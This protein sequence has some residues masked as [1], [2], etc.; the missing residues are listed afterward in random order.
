MNE[1]EQ[2]IRDIC[3]DDI[4]LTTLSL[5]FIKDF[6]AKCSISDFEKL[7]DMEYDLSQ[8]K[9]YSFC[10]CYR[11]KGCDIDEKGFL[12]CIECEKIISLT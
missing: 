7:K 4:N 3:G 2:Y 12:Y 8:S 5:F 6:I 1:L 11:A 9:E 10:N